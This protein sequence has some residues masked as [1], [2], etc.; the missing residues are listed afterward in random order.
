MFVLLTLYD[1]KVLLQECRTLLP[2]HSSQLWGGAASMDEK[3]FYLLAGWCSGIL[4]GPWGPQQP[5][6]RTAVLQVQ[7]LSRARRFLLQ[8]G[9]PARGWWWGGRSNNDNN[10]QHAE[11]GSD[12]KAWPSP[13]Q[14][15][16]LDRSQDTDAWCTD[17]WW[18][19]GGEGWV[20]VWLKPSGLFFTSC[21]VPH[22]H[23]LRV[24]EGFP[25]WIIM[26][27]GGG[28]VFGCGRS[29][30]RRL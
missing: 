15:Q 26:Q 18:G 25:E 30:L 14:Y 2:L 27:E 24:E 12:A 28:H 11:P 8:L 13:S 1:T 4:Q 19:G 29:V 17:F 7:S 10:I 16:N 9:P 6:T 22:H 5:L 21:L 23:C 20:C 3:L